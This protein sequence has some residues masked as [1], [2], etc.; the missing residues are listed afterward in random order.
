MKIRRFRYS[1]T[2]SGHDK[3]SYIGINQYKR[4][5]SSK[6]QNLDQYRYPIM[7]QKKFQCLYEK[8]KIPERCRAKDSGKF[9][10]NFV[11]LA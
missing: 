6:K 7:N 4:T 3:M 2:K 9:S 5:R 10:S 11:D 1:Q 8:F